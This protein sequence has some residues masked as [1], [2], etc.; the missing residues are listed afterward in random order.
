M[1][2]SYSTN[3]ATSSKLFFFEVLHRAKFFDRGI[4]MNLPKFDLPN[5]TIQMHLKAS[6]VFIKS[7]PINFLAA[8]KS[9]YMALSIS[10]MNL[11]TSMTFRNKNFCRITFNTLHY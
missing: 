1:K 10:K 4:L 2:V 6:A 9:S 7:F 8:L 3:I 5:I 11:H